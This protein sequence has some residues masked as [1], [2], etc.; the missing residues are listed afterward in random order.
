MKIRKHKCPYLVKQRYCGHIRDLKPIKHKK[1]DCTYNKC[2]NCELWK[3]SPSD[4]ERLILTPINSP[5]N[6]TGELTND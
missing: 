3:H 5:A 2:E 6:N 1:I 4:A